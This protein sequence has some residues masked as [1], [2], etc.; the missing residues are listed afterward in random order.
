MLFKTKQQYA[1][2]MYYLNTYIKDIKYYSWGWRSRK[3]GDGGEEKD[4]A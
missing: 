4:L 2:H 3:K 1:L